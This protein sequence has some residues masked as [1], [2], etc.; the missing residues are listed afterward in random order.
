VKKE[1]GRFEER[2]VH[3]ALAVSG[4]IGYLKHS[5]D[6]YTYKD[7]ADFIQRMN[8]YSTLGAQEKKNISRYKLFISLLFRPYFTFIKMYVLKRG[9]LGGLPCF[10]LSV[11]YAYSVFV[12]YAKIKEIKDNE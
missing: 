11:L 12:K 1:K 10:I 5:L 9:F 8:R 4:N 7:I 3:E 6:H 2:L